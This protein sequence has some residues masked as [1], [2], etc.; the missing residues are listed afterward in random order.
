M[1]TRPL[2]AICAALVAALLI[3]FAGKSCAED[4]TKTNKKH[5][6]PSAST[7]S[8]QQGSVPE[9]TPPQYIPD[10]YT[11]ETSTQEYIT[12]T[13]LIG[14]VVET[15]PVTTEADTRPVYVVATD[16]AGNIIATVPLHDPNVPATTLS[17]LEQYEAT[18]ASMEAAQGG[19]VG[20]ASVYEAPTGTTIDVNK[21]YT[22]HMVQD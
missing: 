15:I 3:I 12:V 16:E 20:E 10:A 2:I 21:D 7:I 9:A 22:I 4:I 8:V 14:E 11:T 19:G 17:I 6:R 5:H 18:R 1:Q 13:N